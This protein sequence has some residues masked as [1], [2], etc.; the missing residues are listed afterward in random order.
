MVEEI[1]APDVAVEGGS[2]GGGGGGGV[3]AVVS[4]G[5]RLEHTSNAICPQNRYC[6]TSAG[7]W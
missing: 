5:D 4:G 6:V 1:H 2:G 7:F 3:A